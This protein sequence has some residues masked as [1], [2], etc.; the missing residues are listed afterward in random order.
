MPTVNV[1][2]MQGESLKEME[3][4]EDVFGCEVKP[5]LLHD[6]VVWQMAN[7]G[8]VAPKTKNRSRVSGGGA[9]PFRQ[10]GT[11]RARAGTNRSPLWKGG[12]VI[13]GPNN[14]KFSKKLPRKVRQSALRSA[15][16]MKIEA[17]KLK[18]VDNMVLE[19]VKTR[20]FASAMD[21]LG[22]EKPLVVMGHSKA[23]I[24]LASRNHASSKLIDVMGLNVY[25]ILKYKEILLDVDAVECIE[26]RLS[27]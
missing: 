16:S 7:R 2:N 13:F 6:A 19:D 22:M 1:Y 5:H 9:K 17:G 8:Q 15:L 21:A 4:S 11:G 20:L 23:D 26:E 14:R 10:K 3:L 27:K 25:D 24:S 12:G 18:V